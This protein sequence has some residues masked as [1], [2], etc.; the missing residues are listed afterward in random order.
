MLTKD[1]L[2]VRRRGNRLYPQFCDTKDQELL[3]TAS[4]L[5][6]AVEDSIGLSVGSLEET[7]D[8]LNLE[9]ESVVLGLKKLLMDRLE[10]CED[11]GSTEEFR[12]QILRK[13]EE[14]RLHG[15]YD[16]SED[17][18]EMVA[19]SVGLEAEAIRERFYG[20]LPENKTILGFSSIKPDA[21]LHRWNCAQVQGL[22]LRALHV[23]MSVGPLTLAEKRGFFRQLKFY[24]LLSQ[25]DSI[26]VTSDDGKL[27][28]LVVHLSGPMSL[29][30][31]AQNYGL[32]IAQFYPHVLH[33][34]RYSIEAD[35]KWNN[36]VYEFKIDQSCGIK[37]HYKQ[38]EPYVP[39]EL[40]ACL[41]SFNDKNRGVNASAGDA[42][43][44]IGRE[45]YCFP[46][47]TLTYKDTGRQIHVELFH[48]WHIQQLKQRIEALG[49]NPIENYRIGVCRSLQNQIDDGVKSSPFFQKQ[50]F[51]FRDFPSAKSLGGL[52]EARCIL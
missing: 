36:E 41:E 4:V 27:S 40:L 1:Q 14:L 45:S 35:I 46:D 23:R 30:D 13:A 21:L 12:W 16:S 43:V 32:R 22:L 48:R 10:V 28:P 17:F 44:H 38:K 24:R 29:F 31:Q 33:F 6:E 52:L 9:P 2:R 49:K 7:L 18:E 11:D 47:L 25:V 26:P 39:P 51:W 42:F 20:D 3:D 37:S 19:R 15:D 8:D 5:V 34:E 50:S